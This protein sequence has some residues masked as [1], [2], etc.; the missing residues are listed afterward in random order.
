MVKLEG[1]HCLEIASEHGGECEVLETGCSLGG[2]DNLAEN[3]G[4]NP[5]NV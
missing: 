1:R 4:K 2:I 3:A 5:A